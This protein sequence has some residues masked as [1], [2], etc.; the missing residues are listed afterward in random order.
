MEPVD[1]DLFLRKYQPSD[2]KIASEFLTTWLP[3]LSRDLCSDCV[4]VLSRRIRS[5]DSEHSCNTTETVSRDD[6]PVYDH[7]LEDDRFINA[8]ETA[9]P[10]MS[11]DD[12]TQEDGFNEEEEQ[13]VREDTTK[14]PQK[15]KLSRDEREQFR[16][17]N[18]KRMKVFSCYEKVK[19]RRV[20]ILE[21]LELHTGVFS[22]AEQKRIVDYVYELQEKGRKGELQERTF[23]APHKWMRGKG[24]VTIQFGCCY[25]YAT[26]KAGNPPGILQHGAV[27]PIPLLFKVIIRRLVG[28]HVLPPTCVPDSCIVNIYDEGDCIPPHIDNHDFLRPFCTVSFLSECDILFGSNLKIEGPGEFS[29][30]Y[31]LPLPVGS[32]LVLKGNGADVAKHCVPAVPQKRISITFR[33]MDESKRPVGFTPDL[34][35][36]GIKPLPY[37]QTTL[38][39]PPAVAAIRPSRWGN[40]QN[41]GNY[42]SRGG[43]QRKHRESS[44]S[45][46]HSESR[47][48]SPTSRRRGSSRHSPNTAYRPKV[49]SN[50]T[51]SD[52][53]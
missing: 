37:E 25:N 46:H 39:T 2:I 50:N 12:M 53:V 3:F 5:L 13:K 31:S 18:V 23:T 35:L 19:G 10:K 7:N 4:H 6:K 17:V 21:G 24:R 20:D 9:S 26:D 27:D 28:W 40:D 1:N 30:S 11:W 33:K 48:R 38:N 14:T 8:S 16:F 34:D 44:R 52:N 15:R 32:V 42:N 43:G 41:G 47:E 49:H 29:G 45:Y 51:S 22:A 36:Q